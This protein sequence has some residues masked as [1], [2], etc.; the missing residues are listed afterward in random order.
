MNTQARQS[1]DW[2][3]KEE[4]EYRILKHAFKKPIIL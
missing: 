2:S 3:L 1:E 4:N